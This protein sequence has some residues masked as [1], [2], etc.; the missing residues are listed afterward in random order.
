VLID[1]HAHTAPRSNCSTTTL[2]ELV[3]T[4]R[5]RGLDALCITEHD[6]TWPDAE[7]ADLSRLLDFPLIPGVEL[8]T[9]V[10][11]VLA[12]GPLEKPLWMGYRLEELVAEAEHA[13]LALVLPH[14]V[15]RLAGERAVRGGRVPPPAEEVA[16]LDQWGAVHAIEVAST[17]TTALEQALTA[18]A[19]T[20]RPRPAV[21]A[22]DAHAPGRAGAFATEVDGRVRD[23]AALATT[24]RAG[25][26][27]PVRS[28]DPGGTADEADVGVS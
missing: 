27:A 13:P 4:A 25:H 11:H 9:D 19:L 7:L 14:P 23:A 2:E 26:V 3:A 17:Q 5:A 28:P 16:A 18:A 15:R 20:V 22:S 12:F 21:G 1:I 24:I 6:V 8:T 10:G